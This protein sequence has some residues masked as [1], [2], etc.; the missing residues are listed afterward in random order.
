ME[1]L[2][3]LCEEYGYSCQI[4]DRHITHHLYTQS[5]MVLFIGVSRPTLN[6]WLNLLKIE[7][8]INFSRTEILLNNYVA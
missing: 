8:C 6:V 5:D 3:K 2:Q 1:I 4:T 7:N